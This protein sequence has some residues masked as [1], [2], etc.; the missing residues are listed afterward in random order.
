[1]KGQIKYLQGDATCPIGPGFKYIV[2]ICNDIG[3]WGKGFVLAISKRWSEPEKE[4]RRGGW[5]L[6]QTT[7]IPVTVDTV[8]VNMVAQKGIRSRHN[9]SPINYAALFRCLDQVSDVISIYNK[10]NDHTVHMPR[11]GCGLGGSSWSKIEPI[12]QETLCDEGINVYVYD[13]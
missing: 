10:S 4:Y 2:H 11:I 9:P 13:Y 3:A 8:V 6:G 1:M 12:I 7:F 5:K